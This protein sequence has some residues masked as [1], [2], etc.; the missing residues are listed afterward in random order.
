MASVWLARDERLGRLV[1]VKLVGDTLAGDE[2]WV[3]RFTREARAAAGVAHHGVVSVFDYGVEDGRPFLVMEYVAGGDLAKRLKDPSA[4]PLDAAAVSHELLDALRAVHGAGI[5]H[6]DVKPANVLLDEHGHVRLTDFGIAQHV[7]ATTLTQTGMVVGTL[8]YLAPEVAA[9][10]KATAS[11]DLYSAGMV[12]RELAGEPPA[13]RLASL[14]ATLTAAHAGDRPTT[15]EQAIALLGGGGVAAGE[16]MATRLLPKTAPTRATGAETAVTQALHA[17]AATA[18]V[19]A[20]A[21]R[22]PLARL[23][24]PLRRRGI[25]PGLAYAVA[26]LAALVLIVVIAGSGGSGSRSAATASPPAPAA[27]GAP[28]SQQLSA[29]NRIINRAQARH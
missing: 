15:A 25:S 6:R 8:R 3:R 22:R 18:E 23:S 14:I 16:T 26:G 10:E 11:S 2:H 12:I 9:G 13:A 24:A 29:L 7:D 21:A 4:A 20:V 1:A 19:T 17:A 5:L 27:A 28:L